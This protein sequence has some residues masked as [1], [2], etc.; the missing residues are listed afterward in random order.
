M[1]N[2]KSKFVNVDG[3]KIHY[4][5]EG[6]AN[7]VILLLHGFALSCE[8]WNSN[9]SELAKNHRVI[10]LDILGFGESDIPKA[11]LPVE[12]LPDFIFHFMQKINVLSAKFVGHSMGGMIAL[13][14]AQKYPKAVESLILVGSAGFK[15]NI[16]FHFR[17][18]CLPILGELMVKPNKRGLKHSLKRGAYNA[19]SIPDDLVDHLYNAIKKPNR[20][21]YYLRT[22]RNA[23]SFFGF[24]FKILKTVQKEAKELKIP[25][26]L[27]WGRDDKIVY[28]SHAFRAKKLMPHAQLEI[29]DVCGHYPQL[30]HPEKFNQLVGDFFK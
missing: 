2:I 14:V 20:G 10:A 22:C 24:K 7:E 17:L 15:M 4:L 21:Q 5:E 28:L 25:I 9:I 18:F 1:P 3:Y 23:I 29:F 8:I 12:F 26:L 16:P 6:S 11:N 27:I 13:W 19:K 30:E